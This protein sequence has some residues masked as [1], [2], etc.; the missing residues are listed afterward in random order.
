MV[1][2][3]DSLL[4]EMTRAIVAAVSPRRIILFGSRARGPARSESDI[5][6]IVVEDEP[7]GADRSRHQEISRIR[8]ALSRFR[9]PKDILVFG[10]SEMSQWERSRNHVIGVGLRDGRVLYERP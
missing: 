10:A 8:A 2:V 6:L 4:Q 9:V 5:D 3:T 1:E 7:F